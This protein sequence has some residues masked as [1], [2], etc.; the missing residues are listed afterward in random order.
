MKGRLIRDLAVLVLAAALPALLAAFFHPELRDGP[1]PPLKA[2]EITAKMAIDAG[3][4]VLWVDARDPARFEEGHVPGA[5]CFPPRD[6]EE[7]LLLLI[8][9][10]KH[11]MQV[12]IYCDRAS[13]DLSEQLAIRLRD[14]GGLTD[15]YFL[16]GGWDAWKSYRR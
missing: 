3:A 9:Q 6:W 12:V 1:V 4:N 7:R 13:C 8:E 5:M 2:F 10:W 11:G 16:R 15:V 14:E